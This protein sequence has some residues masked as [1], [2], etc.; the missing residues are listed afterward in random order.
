VLRVAYIREYGGFEAGVYSPVIS[1]AF[2]RV[3]K[4]LMARDLGL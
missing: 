4:W 1:D 3:A 2:A